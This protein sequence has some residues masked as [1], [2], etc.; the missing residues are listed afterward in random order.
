[1]L[2]TVKPRQGAVSRKLRKYCVDIAV[3]MEYNRI[4]EIILRKE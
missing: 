1:M 3:L 4:T 2:L